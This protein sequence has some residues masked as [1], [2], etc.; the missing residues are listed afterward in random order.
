MYNPMHPRK[1]VP[2]PKLS[3]LDMAKEIITAILTFLMYAACALLIYVA[4]ISY[5]VFRAYV[6]P[7]L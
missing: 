5:S 4:L 6:F 1:T 3:P 7:L 2:E